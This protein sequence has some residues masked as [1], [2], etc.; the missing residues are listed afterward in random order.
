MVSFTSGQGPSGYT[1]LSE[2][3][4]AQAR[5]LADASNVLPYFAGS[6]GTVA[7]CYPDRSLSSAHINRLQMIAFLAGVLV[8]GLLAG[9]FVPK[10]PL[11]V[12]RR[13]FEVYSWLAAFYGDELVG[14]YAKQNMPKNMDLKEIRERMGDLK[15]RYGF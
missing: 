5:A 14:D 10:L 3:Y 7:R 9:L 13:G 6:A 8:L 15:F 12:P 11:Q 1:E 4:F 2:V